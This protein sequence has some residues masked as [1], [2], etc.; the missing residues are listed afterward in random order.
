[1]KSNQG[2]THTNKMPDKRSCRGCGNECPR[3]WRNRLKHGTE[4][5]P[6]K[7]EKKRKKKEQRAIKAELDQWGDA[8][9]IEGVRIHLSNGNY[10]QYHY[11]KDVVVT[12]YEEVGHPAQKYEVID[13]NLDFIDGVTLD[14]KIIPCSYGPCKLSRRRKV[15]Q[16]KI[17]L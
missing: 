8:A 2:I 16:N 10:T 1:M 7:N 4:H 15:A 11:A 17:A 5:K 12:H 9:K 3:C 13:P 14:T 6:S